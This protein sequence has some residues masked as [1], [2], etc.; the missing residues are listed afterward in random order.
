MKQ[1]GQDT[2]KSICAGDADKWRAALAKIEQQSAQYNK[3]DADKRQLAESC[4]KRLGTS[5]A[6]ERWAQANCEAC[7]EGHSNCASYCPAAPKAADAEEARFFSFNRS[8]MQMAA[9]TSRKTNASRAE[10][11]C[12]LQYLTRATDFD[13]ANLQR[14]KSLVGLFGTP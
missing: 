1:L 14:F 3:K 11:Y 4:I 7:P 5:E 2:W 12:N 6:Q 9:T 8:D 10:L 13:L